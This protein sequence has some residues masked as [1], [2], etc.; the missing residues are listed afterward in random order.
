[1][2]KNNL[3]EINIINPS[4]IRCGTQIDQKGGIAAQSIYTLAKS[5]DY[6]VSITVR[7]DKPNIY[8]IRV[9]NKLRKDGSIIKKIEEW[10]VREEYVYDLTTE[11]H[12]FQ[13]GVGCLIVHNTD[14]NFSCYRF[15][16]DVVPVDKKE[17]LR[18]WKEIIKFSKELI[19]PFIPEEHQNKW[20]HDFKR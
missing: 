4:N 13:A 1:M 15:R 5:L 3:S 19:K 14:S 9:A 6:E 8:R 17:S 18:L 16:E 10:N 11:N 2:Y 12:H 7:K 20:V